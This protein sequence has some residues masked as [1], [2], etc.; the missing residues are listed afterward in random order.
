MFAAPGHPA[1]LRLDV[2]HFQ[3]LVGRAFR[4]EWSDFISAKQGHHDEQRVCY[5]ALMGILGKEM[6]GA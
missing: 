5:E 4:P 3:K 6:R 1:R 2:A